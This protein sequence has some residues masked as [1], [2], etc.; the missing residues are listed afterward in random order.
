MRMLCALDVLIAMLVLSI[1][2]NAQTEPQSKSFVI[3]GNRGDA[4]VV[5]L[6]G[7]EYIQLEALVRITHGSISFQNGQT[8]LTLPSGEN[9]KTQSSA[10]PNGLSKDF[11]KAG[12]EELSLLREWASPLANAIQ[13]GFPVTEAWVAGYQSKAKRGLG[14]A[15]AAASTEGDHRAFALLNNEFELVRQWSDKLV[16]ARKSLSVANYALSQDALK[17][18]PLSIRIVTCE[19]VLEPMLAGGVFQDDSSCH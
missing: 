18:D 12:I 16:E 6:N 5:L 8:E 10:D 4:T 9:G 7:H 2:S 17:N 11:M 3:N 13:N 15:S 19:H 14:M 1:G